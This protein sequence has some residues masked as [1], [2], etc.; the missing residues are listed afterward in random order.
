MK[1]ESRSAGAGGWGARPWRGEAAPLAGSCPLP[2]MASLAPCARGPGRAA[3]MLG[4]IA[5]SY[6][7]LANHFSLQE[8]FAFHS[9]QV[10]MV[11]VDSLVLV[12][13]SSQEAHSTLTAGP[14]A[15]DPSPVTGTARPHRAPWHRRH[16]SAVQG[17]GPGAETCEPPR[18]PVLFGMG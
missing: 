16:L 2:G 17:E 3:A 1:A 10:G 8:L 14:G 9:A 12:S 6:T 4:S 7:A 18:L 11:W 15:A 5:W 13:H